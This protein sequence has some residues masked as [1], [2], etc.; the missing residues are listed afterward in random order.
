MWGLLHGPQ[1]GA[2]DLRFEIP[3]VCAALL[4]SGEVDI[5][6]VPVIELER[7]N[8]EMLPG[9]GIASR[10]EVRSILVIS[11]FPAVQIQTLAVDASS[12]TSVVLA[13]ILLEKKFGVQSKLIEALPDP[14]EMLQAADAC[15]V[16][17]DPAL[18]VNRQAVE[19]FFIYD[20][21]DE[22]SSW[23][24]LPMVYAVWAA[25]AGFDWQWAH[26]I[27]QASWSFG[28]TRVDE[29]AKAECGSRGISFDE[30]IEYLTRHIHFELSDD[31]MEGLALY[32][33]VARSI[34]AV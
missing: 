22:W 26:G 6:L 14:G 28:R 15:L 13:R 24:G 20:L 16:I 9:L 12:R 31:Y 5:G 21:G 11:K 19:N 4:R 23:T 10:G 7:Q 25:R 34:G 3:S 27:L 17:G 18:R 8:L 1:R 33:S 29:I 30:A 2:L 32:R